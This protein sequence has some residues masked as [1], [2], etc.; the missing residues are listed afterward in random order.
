MDH[1]SV[2]T[3]RRALEMHSS[4]VHFAE[5]FSPIDVSQVLI[6]VGDQGTLFHDS[7]IHWPPREGWLC[8]CSTILGRSPLW[9][10]S[11]V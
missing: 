3:L 9:Q 8:K 6:G 1:L 7:M 2:P 5:Q 10:E 4:V 11:V